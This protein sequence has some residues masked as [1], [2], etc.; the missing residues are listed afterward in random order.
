M[1]IPAGIKY[2]HLD[3]V[4]WT[5]DELITPTKNLLLMKPFSEEE[6]RISISSSK[7][8]KALGP[9]VYLHI[10]YCTVN[11]SHYLERIKIILKSFSTHY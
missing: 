9:Y 2:A 6:I 7:S 4:F 5:Q 1:G 10:V 11:Y 3:E 8:N